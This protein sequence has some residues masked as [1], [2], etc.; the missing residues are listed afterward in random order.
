VCARSDT[1]TTARLQRSHLNFLTR[2]GGQRLVASRAARMPCCAAT[3]DENCHACVGTQG[4]LSHSRAL[5]TNISSGWNCRAHPSS[6]PPSGRH[7]PAHRTVSAAALIGGCRP[8]PMAWRSCR[9]SA[10]ARRAV[11]GAAG[12]IMGSQ[13]YRNVGESQPVL[14]MIDPMIS[15]RTRTRTHEPTIRVS[16]CLGLGMKSTSGAAVILPPTRPRGHDEPAHAAR[17]IDAPCTH[18]LRH[19]DPMHSHK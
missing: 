2:T 12:E 11:S 17:V 9:R 15:P 3:D 6:R 5:S 1:R 18:C 7:R 4:N 10:E 13:K 14:I 8:N 19:G 16:R